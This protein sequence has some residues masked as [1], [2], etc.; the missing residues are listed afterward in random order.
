MGIFKKKKKRII[1]EGTCS[2]DMVIKTDGITKCADIC[3][4]LI[5]ALCLALQLTAKQTEI[6]LDLLKKC[7]I[8]EIEKTKEKE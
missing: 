7:A 5:G 6:S 4:T 8:H 3:D 1:I 2:E